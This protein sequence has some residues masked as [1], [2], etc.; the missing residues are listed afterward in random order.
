MIQTLNVFSFT[1]KE[2]ISF[3]VSVPNTVLTFQFTNQHIKK[4]STYVH[5]PFTKF[6]V[7]YMHHLPFTFVQKKKI[8]TI[9]QL[10]FRRQIFMSAWSVI[11]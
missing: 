7:C 4:N 11:L 6:F 9:Y 1:E 10:T 5:A 3:I 2:A 8:C